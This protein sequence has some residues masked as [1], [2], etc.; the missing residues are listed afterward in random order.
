M[1]EAQRARLLENRDFL[2]T[3]T[4]VG[5]TSRGILRGLKIEANPWRIVSH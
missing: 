4:A 2:D 3:V 5:R 1:V